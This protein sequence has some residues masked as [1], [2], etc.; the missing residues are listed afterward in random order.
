MNREQ[1]AAKD[2]RDAAQAR[3]EADPW[4]SD[5][6][7]DCRL[8]ENNRPIV[9]S[10][11]HGHMAEVFCASCYK[12]TGSY[13]TNGWARR[14]FFLCPN[15]ERYG[16]LPGLKTV[17]ESV[18]T[19]KEP[20]IPGMDIEFGDDVTTQM[21]VINK[22]GRILWRSAIPSD[23]IP[24]NLNI[25]DDGSITTAE[26]EKILPPF[27]IAVVVVPEGMEAPSVPAAMQKPITSLDLSS[28]GG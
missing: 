6:L 4:N 9:K 11:Q 20:L 12:A 28:I 5:K 3:W 2:E 24:R 26:G 22:D 18:V 27:R 1:Q 17:S 21:A 8:H 23:G 7:P 16:Q 19:G 15:C 13:I 10:E 14:V 25:N